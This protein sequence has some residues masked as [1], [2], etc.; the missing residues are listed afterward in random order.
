MG[1][2]SP[3]NPQSIDTSYSKFTFAELLGRAEDEETWKEMVEWYKRHPASMG[4]KKKKP[5][6]W[7]NDLENDRK[8]LHSKVQ[9]SILVDLGSALLRMEP[10]AHAFGASGY[11]GVDK[12]LASDVLAYNPLRN[13]TAYL[14][15]MYGKQYDQR[16]VAFVRA[17]MLDFASRLPASSVNFTLNGI[18]QQ[19]LGHRDEDVE[20]R[21][22]E[23]LAREIYRATRKGGIIF[24]TNFH[25][26][27]DVYDNPKVGYSE[28][29]KTYSGNIRFV[30]AYE[31]I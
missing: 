2:D 6:E 3:R 20:Q 16:Q 30:A 26:V 19:I 14:N 4:S 18:G 27:S 13:G 15:A 23:D 17:D 29:L 31:K 9:G 25:R 28:K 21:Y 10:L 7:K 5:L 8:F 24:G 1:P 11:V 12:F 22:A